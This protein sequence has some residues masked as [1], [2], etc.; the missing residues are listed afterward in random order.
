MTGIEVAV[1]VGD[2]DNRPLE[3]IVGKSHCFDEGFPKKQRK[4]AIAVSGEAFPQAFAELPARLI[5]H[6]GWLGA[7]QV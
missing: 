3:R 4:T 5:G 7:T 1:S 2:A 6:R